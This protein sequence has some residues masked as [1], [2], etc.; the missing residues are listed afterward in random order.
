MGINDSVCLLLR[1]GKVGSEGNV[2]FGICKGLMMSFQD[3][4]YLFC[5]VYLFEYLVNMKTVHEGLWPCMVT[6]ECAGKRNL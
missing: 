3:I 6:R 1:L 4:L 5:V 2:C